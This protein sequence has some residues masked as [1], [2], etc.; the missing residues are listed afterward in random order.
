MVHDTL[1]LS[2][3]VKAPQ[4]VIGSGVQKEDMARLMYNINH[5]SPNNRA[6]YLTHEKEG[7]C[8]VSSAQ[9]HVGL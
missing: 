6:L 3:F 4:Q 8:Q 1:R 9:I 5:E 2:L 7:M